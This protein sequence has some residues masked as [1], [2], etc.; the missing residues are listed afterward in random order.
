M[1]TKFYKM[2]ASGNDFIVI[3]NRDRSVKNPAALAKQMCERRV[4]IGADGVLLLEPSKKNA[5]KMRIFNADGSEAE[6][7]GNGARCAALFCHKIFKFEPAFTM[8]TLAGVVDAIVEKET[9]KVKLPDPVD[10]RDLAPLEVKDGIYYFYFIN[11]SV[12][13]AVIFE[14]SIEDFPVVTVGREIRHHEHFQP[15]GTN[16]N[17]VE[18]IDKKTIAIR[19][20]ERGVEDETLACGTGSTASAIVSVLI[21]KCT[22]PVNVRTRGGEVLKISFDMHLYDVTNVYL[23]G[24]AG[25]VYEGAF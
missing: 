19:T 24:K 21:K 17:F 22:S 2:A 9:V 5:I 12:P 14:E 25:F 4:S 13:H 6:M 8:E 18:I 11:T 23:E 3:D 1:K 16:V 7:C 20:Y 15:K 10:F